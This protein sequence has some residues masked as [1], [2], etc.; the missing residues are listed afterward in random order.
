MQ[1][2]LPKGHASCLSSEFTYTSATHTDLGK[3]FARIK[4]TERAV[5]AGPCEG[6]SATRENR[7]ASQSAAQDPPLGIAHGMAGASLAAE[8]STNSYDQTH[9]APHSLHA[10]RPR[11]ALAL[12]WNQARIETQR[13]ARIQKATLL[14]GEKSKSERPLTLVSPSPPLTATRKSLLCRRQKLRSATPGRSA[15]HLDARTRAGQATHSRGP[16]VASRSS[17]ESA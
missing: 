15:N 13:V 10:A 4:A 6:V 12:G 7:H 17:L 11:V 14:D 3:T 8:Q 9:P 1:K 16:T 2:T 5:R